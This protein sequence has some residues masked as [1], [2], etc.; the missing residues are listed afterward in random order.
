MRF[1]MIYWTSRLEFPKLDFSGR[2]IAEI[3]L[4]EVFGFLPKW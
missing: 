1:G 3:D 4:C 2:I